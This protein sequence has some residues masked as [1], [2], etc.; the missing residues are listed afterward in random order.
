M[1][2]WYLKICVFLL[3]FKFSA[4][5]MKLWCCDT[6]ANDGGNIGDGINVDG[7]VIVIELDATVERPIECC[8]ITF[9]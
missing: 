8:R 3:Y 4:Y 6:V 5:K 1:L 9:Q 7:V 2:H